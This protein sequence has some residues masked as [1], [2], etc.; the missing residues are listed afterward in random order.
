MMLFLEILWR[1][2]YYENDKLLLKLMSTSMPE[3]K[4]SLTHMNII[5]S[6]MVV[7]KIVI[8]SYES[9]MLKLFYVQWET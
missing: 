9:L 1:Y 6:F 4:L 3:K 5:I 2:K 8:I 7:L